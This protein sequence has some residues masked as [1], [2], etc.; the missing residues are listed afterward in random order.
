MDADELAR[1]EARSRKQKRLR[2]ATAGAVI[3]RIRY[4]RVP[5]SFVS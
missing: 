4:C 1:I 2:R 3:R 5:L